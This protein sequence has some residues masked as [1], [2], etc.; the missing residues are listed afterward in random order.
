MTVFP[1]LVQ[2]TLISRVTGLAAALGLPPSIEETATTIEAL[3][4]TG[5]RPRGIWRGCRRGHRHTGA[6]VQS[7]SIG[8]GADRPTGAQQTQP[9][10]FLA[11]AGVSHFRLLVLMVQDHI[12][13]V[14][15]APCQ[16]DQG[17]VSKL[18][19]LEDTVVDVSDAIDVVLEHVNAE[20][21]T[22]A[23][24]TVNSHNGVG[25]VEPDAADDR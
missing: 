7:L 6:I 8:T 13:G 18:V 15:Q 21:V 11:V 24:F 2:F 3:Q 12:R 20:G 5:S 19:D 14:A 16:V 1:A 4:G 23:S 17:A 10:A 25:A 22:Q 9:F